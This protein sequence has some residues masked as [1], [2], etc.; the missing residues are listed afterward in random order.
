MILHYMLQKDECLMISSEDP[1]IPENV[2]HLS[3]I[4]FDLFLESFKPGLLGVRAIVIPFSFTDEHK[5]ANNGNLFHIWVLNCKYLRYLDLSGSTF[6]ILPRSIKKL[7]HLR[8][9]ALM[10]NRRIRKLPDSICNLQNLE[11]LI[12]FGCEELETLPKKLR[13]LIN[14]QRMSITTKQSVLPESDIASLCF[15][16]ELNIGD[17]DNLESLFGG[18]KLPALRFLRIMDCKNLKCL[19]LDIHHFPQLED[20]CIADC[21]NFEWPGVHEDMNSVLKLK[22][23]LFSMVNVP[24]SLLAYANTLQTL[25]F[26]ECYE[27]EELPEG[28]LNMTCLKTL[29]ILGCPKLMSLPNGIHG[30]K[31]LEVLVIEDCP[32]LYSKYQ[33]QVGEYWHQISHIK[34]TLINP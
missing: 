33:P 27:L 29:N 8:Y 16:E 19:P 6:E 22:L 5:G 20:L 9:L 34:H 21:E 13:K 25:V 28:V 2:L 18:V 31:A 14:L 4:E 24:H 11:E 12:L 1:N 15:L 26:I 7:K 10:N 32:I 17:C 23:L 3:F 30:L